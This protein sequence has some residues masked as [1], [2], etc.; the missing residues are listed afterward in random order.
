MLKT[1]TQMRSRK[2]KDTLSQTSRK[3]RSTKHV[4]FLQTQQ[5][6]MDTD[7]LTTSSSF[8]AVLA[9]N[10]V[11][12]RTANCKF[13]PLS[14][15]HPDIFFL[16]DNVGTICPLLDGL[17]LRT[18]TTT[19]STVDSADHSVLSGSPQQQQM[20]TQLVPLESYRCISSRKYQVAGQDTIVVF[21]LGQ[22]M[23]NML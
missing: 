13:V 6:P 20:V 21:A 17:S 16:T 15:G 7:H 2:G 18:S 3:K 4:H 23:C 12:Q 10:S 1:R 11:S 5:T 14:T 9:P 22:Y 19:T 8:S